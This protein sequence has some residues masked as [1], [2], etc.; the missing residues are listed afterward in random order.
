MFVALLE[1]LKQK[2]GILRGV[3]VTQQGNGTA[4]TALVYHAGRLLA[5]HEGDLPYQV[6]AAAAA[7]SS[8]ALWLLACRPAAQVCCSS[9]LML[10]QALE[11]NV[12][13]QTPALFCYSHQ[14]ALSFVELG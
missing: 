12:P 14:A 7:G 8:R 6:R 3:P 11:V 2:V 9:H 10:H 13:H 1:V 4:N 5:L